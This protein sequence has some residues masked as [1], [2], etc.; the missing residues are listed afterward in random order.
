MTFRLSYYVKTSLGKIF[1]HIYSLIG[2]VI[3]GKKWP[4]RL[5]WNSVHTCG[6]S[7]ARLHSQSKHAPGRLSNITFQCCPLDKCACIA[8][9][10]HLG[11]KLTLPGWTVPM[12]C[13]SQINPSDLLLWGTWWRLLWPS[14]GITSHALRR[15]F[16]TTLA[17]D[18]LVSV[19]AAMRVAVILLLRL[20]VPIK[21]WGKS[22]AASI[23]ALGLDQKMGK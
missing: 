15:V 5:E 1:I 22:E 9:P 6:C 17:N 8:N 2:V 7:K 23:A 19:Q 3:V 12:Q 11:K 21:L 10:L 20:T 16:V 18:P 13:S 4:I 14:L